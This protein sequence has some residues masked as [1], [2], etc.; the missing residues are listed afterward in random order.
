MGNTALYITDQGNIGV[1]KT[2]GISY[3]F[4]VTG[5]IRATSDVI[6]FSDRRVKKDIVTVDNALNKV[7][8]LRG[9]TYK[10]KDTPD[11][12]TKLG[13]IAQEVLEVLP[14]VVEKD[15][16]GLYSVAYGNMAGV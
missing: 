11:N 10:R 5:T 13:V 9:V 14:E 1:K 6:A 15:D 4:D 8:N 12:K 2:S 7:I 16:K 3:A